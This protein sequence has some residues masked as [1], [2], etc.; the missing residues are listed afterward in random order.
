MATVCQI[1][2]P[3]KPIT[4]PHAEGGRRP[5]RVRD[6]RRGPPPHPFG[7]AVAPDAAGKMPWCRS[8]IGWSQ[9][10]WPTRWA[11]IAQH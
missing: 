7:F 5:R 8:S 1:D 6:L 2:E 11:E 3:V 9:T 4:V 10:A